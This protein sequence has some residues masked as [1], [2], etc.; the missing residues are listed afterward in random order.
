M[1]TLVKKYNTSPT[2]SGSLY[3][4]AIFIF[5]LNIYHYLHAIYVAY[6]S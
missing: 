6:F 3:F 4:F 5:M 1:D 2:N